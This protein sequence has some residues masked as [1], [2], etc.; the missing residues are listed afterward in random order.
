MTYL[1]DT[2]VYSQP[3]RNKPVI[4]SME[5]WSEAGDGRCRVSVVSHAEILFGLH[6]E[7]NEAR[8]RRYRELLEGR[9]QPVASDGA[10]WE[11]FA[12]CKARQQQH[13]QQ[14]A[15][16]DLLIAATA[17]VHGFTVATLNRQDFSRIEGVVWEDWST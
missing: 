7:N 9:L 14:V 13:G 15:D 6:W 8:W 1:L 17:M 12:V 4:P 5:R 10:V 11:K 3:L 16:L 2:S